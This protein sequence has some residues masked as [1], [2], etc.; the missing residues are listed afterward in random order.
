MLP[1]GGV[2]SLFWR[3]EVGSLQ[4]RALPWGLEP[5]TLWGPLCCEGLLLFYHSLVH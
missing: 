3:K 5:G 2:S 4:R 1:P